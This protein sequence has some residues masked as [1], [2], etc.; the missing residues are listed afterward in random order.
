MCIFSVQLFSSNGEYSDLYH[1]LPIKDPNH[2]GRGTAEEF[3]LE[4]SL[5]AVSPG[6]RE[7]RTPV[8]TKR[9]TRDPLYPRT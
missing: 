5:A 4:L 8:T 7:R 9:V 6:R 2:K 1:L 3:P